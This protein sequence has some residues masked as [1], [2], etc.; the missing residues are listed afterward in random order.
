MSAI[1]PP[2]GFASCSPG[3]SAS[4][5]AARRGA[6]GDRPALRP[7]LVIRRLVQM[8]EV[9][10]VVKHPE[11]GRIFTFEESDWALI[12][13]LDGTR[14]PDEVLEEYRR[15]V[16]GAEVPPTLVLDF[17]DMLRKID[18]VAQSTA[19]RNL[20][21]LEKARTARRRAAEEK[22]EGFN[23]FFLM[24]KVLDPNRFLGR[25]AHLVRW[26]WRPPTV[27]VACVGFLFTVSVFVGHFGPLWNE[28]LELYAFL[29]K[30]FWDAVQFF[31]ILSCIGAI[32]EFSHGYVTRFYGGEV[33]DIGI[34]LLYFMPAF[35]CDT[36]DSLLFESKWQR[37]WVT[38]A[39]I[40]VEA[41]LCTAATALWVVSYPDTLVH[42]LAYKTMLFTGVS[43][44]FFNINPLI[45]IDGYHAL[46]SLLE[47]PEL[48]EESIRWLG[49]L[50]QRHV[51]RLDV[52]VPVPSRRKRRIFLVYAP[53]A[54]A[55]TG[56][57]MLFIWG[58]LRNFWV[59][60]APDLGLVLALVTMGF[61][62]KGR[63]RLVLRTARLFYLDKKELAMS[64]R[65][66]A[67][68]A[69]AAAL[70]LALVAVPWS[71]RAVQLDATLAPA[72]TARLDAPEDGTVGPVLVREGD[73]VGLGQPLLSLVSP[74]LDA[75][76]AS[77]GAERGALAREAG[78]ARE[79]AEPRVAFRAEARGAAVGAALASDE[80]RRDALTVRSPFPGRVLT[81]RTGDLA[82]RFVTAGTPLVEVGDCS[83]LVAELPISERRLR[84][85]RIGD[86]VLLQLRARPLELVRGR[87]VSI[88][89]A[90]T[91]ARPTAAGAAPPLRP[92]EMP[93]R[94]VVRAVFDNDGGA[95]LPGMAGTARIEGARTSLLGLGA[96]TLW[97][98]L[99]GVAW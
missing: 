1:A 69:A 4:A 30:P 86:A 70:L 6:P 97:R 83:R 27:A 40:Y 88:A 77:L 73:A 98:W 48:R 81:P 50:F 72:R 84:D 96:R 23:I 38:I 94:V 29:R 33:H 10:W 76:L 41:I 47:I 7:D 68:L 99:Q 3:L 79:R 62:F 58:L 75:R 37:L 85:V 11:S 25:T 13:L 43:T 2:A 20:A 22:A 28:T 52:P 53:L 17:L 46:T 74:A 14:T 31:L 78:G 91:P 65:S 89:P 45:K 39:G 8:G 36:T 66:R 18:F 15:M 92:P 12:A 80:G 60:L 51:L 90:A 61:F 56:V 63:L 21:L 57:I 19:E 64:K 95:L 55:Y 32:H 9:T 71:R 5:L 87:V 34:A 16:G 49:A 67:P 44:V 35:Y 93:D 42:E 59:R 26:I 24:F 54:L 82:G